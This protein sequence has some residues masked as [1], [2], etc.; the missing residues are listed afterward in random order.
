MTNA[1]ARTLRSDNNAG[2]CPEAMQALID[3][4]DGHMVGYGDDAITACAVDAFR[5][6]FGD[7]SS[8]H[9]VATGTA[10]NVL[11][12]ASLTETR[13]EAGWCTR[14]RL[15]VPAISRVAM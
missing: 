10:A 5:S 2:L 9:F 14:M 15:P 11:S 3:A 7:E 1:H 13:P 8:V 6:I 4:D 12:I